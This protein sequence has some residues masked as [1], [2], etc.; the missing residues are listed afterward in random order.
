MLI[1]KTK[2]FHIMSVKG[3]NFYCIRKHVNMVWQVLTASAYNFYCSYSGAKSITDIQHFLF[4][5]TSPKKKPK[6]PKAIYHLSKKYKATETVK[7][8]GKSSK[9]YSE[10]GQR[11]GSIPSSLKS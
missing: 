1:S 3:K 8:V 9:V 7:H 11:I 4:L 5:D 10:M 6:S 2:F